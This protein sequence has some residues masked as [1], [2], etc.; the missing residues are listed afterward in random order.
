MDPQMQQPRWR[1]VAV[2]GLLPV[3]YSV[4]LKGIARHPTVRGVMI[5]TLKYSAQKF[6]AML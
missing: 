4:E 2:T 6:I 5:I 1:R 3:I